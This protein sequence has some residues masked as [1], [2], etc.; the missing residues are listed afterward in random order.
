ML[1]VAAILGEVSLFAALWASSSGAIPVVPERRSIANAAPLRILPLG[2]S[3]TAGYLEPSGNSYRRDLECFLYSGGNG[4]EYMGSLNSGDWAD[5]L[6]DGFDGQRIDQISVEGEP[7]INGT[8]KANI[9]LVHA[10]TNDMIQDAN[11]Q[12]APRR[13]GQLIDK[14]HGVNPTALI[15]VAQIIVNND[16]DIN[17]RIQDFN[18]EVPNIVTTRSDRGVPVR[19]VSMAA[20]TVD[21]LIE[22]THPNAGGYL[23]M[24][25]AWYPAI[26]Q[27]GT[28]GLISPAFGNFTNGGESSMPTGGGACS[29]LKD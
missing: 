18:E 16:T 3:I 23:K 20:V 21:D 9:F 5:N 13:L 29:E 1:L 11:V 26:V 25:N 19:V 28:D 12:N 17:D 6:N 8:T 4:V 15:L 10:G 2:D 22:G 27:A 14:I 7:E 24:A